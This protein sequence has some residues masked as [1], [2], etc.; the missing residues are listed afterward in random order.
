MQTAKL[1]LKLENK[2]STIW[3]NH[4]NKPDILLHSYIKIR[5]KIIPAQSAQYYSFYETRN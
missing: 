4:V 3:T 1:A 2:E 5:M